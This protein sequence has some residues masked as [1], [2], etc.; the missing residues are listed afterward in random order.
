VSE[1]TTAVYR[2]EQQERRVLFADL[3]G[4]HAG[5]QEVHRSDAHRVDHLAEAVERGRTQAA[6]L[7]G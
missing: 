7:R 1:P 3:P 6:G 4:V 5:L 2:R